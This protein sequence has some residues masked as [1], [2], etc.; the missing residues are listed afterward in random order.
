MNHC[1]M[2]QT[3]QIQAVIGDAARDG[4]G[5]R[6]YCGIW[7]LTS[8][9]RPFNVFGNSYAGL[10]PGEIRGKSP[11]LNI[12]DNRTCILSRKADEAYPVEVRAEYRVSEPYHI[13]HA[14]SF[15]DRKDVRQKGCTFREV[16]W[17]CYMNCPDD[18]RLHFLSCSE[19]RR[20][21]SPSHG[22]ACNIAP[23]YLPE[24]ELENWPIKSD[25]R[26]ERLDDRP[27]HWD[28]YEQ[29]IQLG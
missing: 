11:T 16:S 24:R 23:S 28:R 3:S 29:S 20:Y 19:W 17:C 18:P 27:F 1:T 2:M 26:E 25:W 8:K 12:I 10:I 15:V 7:S 22:V 6:Q 13:D 21:I 5:G 9:H 14:L 4:V